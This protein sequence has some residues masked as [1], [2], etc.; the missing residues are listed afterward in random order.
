LITLLL[1]EVM[2]IWRYQSLLLIFF[3]TNSQFY[4]YSEFIKSEY[5]PGTQSTAHQIQNVIFMS[6]N[7]DKQLTTLVLTSSG[8]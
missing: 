5:W 2:T 8:H 7:T 4:R 1:S 6:Q 3:I